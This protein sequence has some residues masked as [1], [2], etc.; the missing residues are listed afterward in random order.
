M[1]LMPVGHRRGAE[2][3]YSALRTCG[4]LT[5][6]LSCTNMAML[7][8]STISKDAVHQSTTGAVLQ[9]KNNA[10]SHISI[11]I[12]IGDNSSSSGDCGV[13]GGVVRHWRGT[14]VKD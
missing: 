7:S 9:T 4:I 2:M 11:S 10:S 1:F 3:D 6:K 5:G 12:T 8:D 13:G 14:G